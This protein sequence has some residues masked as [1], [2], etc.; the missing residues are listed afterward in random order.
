MRDTKEQLIDKTLQLWQRRTTRPLS[1]EDAR[2]IIENITGFFSILREWDAAER[3]S[4]S[5]SPPIKLERRLG[6]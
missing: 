5:E 2:Q 4:A 6:K 3:N 1:S